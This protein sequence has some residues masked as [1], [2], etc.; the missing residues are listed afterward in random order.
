M[1]WIKLLL[2]VLLLILVLG[3]GLTSAC[4]MKGRLGDTSI[5]SSAERYGLFVLSRAEAGYPAAWALTLLLGGV[6]AVAARNA[7]VTTQ[8]YSGQTT[9]RL[10]VRLF[11]W[12]YVAGS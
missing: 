1:T 5:S 6:A 4:T 8:A 2:G 3:V 11:G 9:W 10:T 12:L 7:F